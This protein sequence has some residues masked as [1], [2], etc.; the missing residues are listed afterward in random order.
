MVLP[1][2]FET[3]SFQIS[4]HEQ[5]TVVTLSSGEEIILLGV[6][7]EDLDLERDFRIGNL[8]VRMPFSLISILLQLILDDTDEQ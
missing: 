6:N 3:G 7:Q 2:G 8:S 1:T 4:Q 5:G